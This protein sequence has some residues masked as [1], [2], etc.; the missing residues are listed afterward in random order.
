MKINQLVLELRQRAGLT[1]AELAEKLG[2]HTRTVQHWEHGGD[3]PT[4]GYAPGAEQLEALAKL[5]GVTVY[6]AGK[7]WKISEASWVRG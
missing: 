3:D 6:T 7:G 1:Q 5:A 4:R 2:L